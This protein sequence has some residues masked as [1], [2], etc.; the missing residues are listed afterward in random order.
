MASQAVSVDSQE[1]YGADHT[2]YHDEL[3]T[4]KDG[5]DTMM[6]VVGAWM[7]KLASIDK[8][9]Y[10]EKLSLDIEQLATEASMLISSITMVLNGPP[11]EEHVEP[12]PMISHAQGLLEKYESLRPHANFLIEPA[13]SPLKRHPSDESKIPA[14]K[15]LKVEGA[16]AD[17]TLEKPAD[18]DQESDEEGDSD[19]P[20]DSLVS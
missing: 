7:H 10:V 13:S 2:E 5:L 8:P 3:V 12:K 20:Q 16:P 4:A 19:I 9:R 14:K 18:A 17:A 6:T 1:E 15:S 11:P